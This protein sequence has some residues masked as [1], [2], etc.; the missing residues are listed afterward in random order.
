MRF[1]FS[2]RIFYFLLITFVGLMLALLVMTLIMHGGNGTVQ[3][4]IATVAQDVLLF[5]VPAIATSVLVSYDGGRMLCVDRMPVALVLLMALVVYVCGIP[6]MN[7]L[8]AWNES[9]TLP[10]SLAPLEEAMRQSEDAAK[11]AVEILFGGTSWG[12]LIVCLLI[13][14]VLAGVS[15]ELFF[16]GAMQRLLSSGRM[17]PH[18]AIWVTAV[19]FS[20]F[21]MQFFGFFPRLILGAF[22]GYLLYWSGSVWLPAMIHVLNNSLVVWTTWYS[23][24]VP[25]VNT[26]DID[27]IGAD[28]MLMIVVSVV[29]VTGA[30]V[31]LKDITKKQNCVTR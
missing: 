15:E 23:R 11:E 18:A 5:I 24:R 22:F 2:L 21:H 31:L 4:R 30:L 12:D 6:A 1:S 27:K 14:G 16:R 25:D 7:A 3:M 28:S 29:L 9:L 13:V 17:G 20:V 10:A 19:L 8:V 26:V